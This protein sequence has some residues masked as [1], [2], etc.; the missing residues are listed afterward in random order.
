MPDSLIFDCPAVV[1]MDLS[2]FYSERLKDITMARIEDLKLVRSQKA[3]IIGRLLRERE[4]RP[5]SKRQEENLSR[6]ES[7][8]RQKQH[9]MRSL[10]LARSF[11]AETPYITVENKVRMGNSPLQNGTVKRLLCGWLRNVASEEE[12]A[13]WVSAV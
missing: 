13:R 3:R 2:P 12:I 5:N 4:H 7:L 1:P 9:E 11:L 8:R 6:I 10:H